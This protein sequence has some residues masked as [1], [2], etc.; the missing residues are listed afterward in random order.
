MLPEKI[1]GL[2]QQIAVLQTT[3][4][5]PAFYDQPFDKTQATLD[6][7]KQIQSELD[8]ATARWVELE[9]MLE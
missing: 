3:V 6:E 2:E 7:F 9:G 4:G 8:E 1:E 5:D